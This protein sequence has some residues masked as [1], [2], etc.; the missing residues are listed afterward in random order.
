MKSR[1]KAYLFDFDGTLVDTMGGFADIAGRVING[2]HPHISFEAARRRY[3]ETSGIP[4]FQ[5]L[6]IICPEDPTN[7]Q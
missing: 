3:L 5:Q 4:F 2:F 1:K 7:A 6:E